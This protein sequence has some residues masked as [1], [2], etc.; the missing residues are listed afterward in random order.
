MSV[1]SIGK[2]KNQEDYEG[3]NDNTEDLNN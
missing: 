2:E 1:N 3:N